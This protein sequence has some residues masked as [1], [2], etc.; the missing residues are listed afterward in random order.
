M[1]VGIKAASEPPLPRLRVL[2]FAS[3]PT[4]FPHSRQWVTVAFLTPAL[5][6]Y[7]MHSTCAMNVQT[8]LSATS[9]GTVRFGPH[10]RALE[11][12]SS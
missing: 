7:G 1:L 8:S 3:S 10:P 11:R 6:N 5:R 12:H 9:R 2:K 4:W